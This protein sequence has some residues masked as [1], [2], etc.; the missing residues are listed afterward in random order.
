[1]HTDLL[2][3]AAMLSRVID[4]TLLELA[5][6]L[7]VICQLLLHLL[8]GRLALGLLERTR[9]C[10]QASNIEEKFREKSSIHCT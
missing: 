2:H 5:N 3:D 1:M 9:V 6:V 4:K 7:E 8:H 10:K